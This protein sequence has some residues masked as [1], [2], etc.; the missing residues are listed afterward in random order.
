VFDTGKPIAQ[1]ARD[2][3]INPGTPGNRV[4]AAR[5]AVTTVPGR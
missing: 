2:L 5:R 4:A 3:G 1:L